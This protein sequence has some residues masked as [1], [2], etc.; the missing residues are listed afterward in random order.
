MPQQI[1]GNCGGSGV[2]TVMRQEQYTEMVD[3]KP[4]VKFTQRDVQETC[5]SCGGRGQIDY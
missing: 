1:C 3:G 5:T 2:K 4:V